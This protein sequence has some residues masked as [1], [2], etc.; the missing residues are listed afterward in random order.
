[1]TKK[2]HASHKPSKKGTPTGLELVSADAP[3]IPPE[4]RASA[5]HAA[6]GG[7]IVN[8]VI[9]G[10]V[11]LG[12]PGD[13]ALETKKTKK[14]TTDGSHAHG[15]TSATTTTDATLL[16]EKKRAG[17][18]RP[19]DHVVRPGA[20]AVHE[21][22]FEMDRVGRMHS[23]SRGPELVEPD[24]GGA[25][26]LSASSGPL[27]PEYAEGSAG[28]AGTAATGDSYLARLARKRRKNKQAAG[29]VRGR[30]AAEFVLTA[31]VEPLDVPRP[32]EIEG[33]R[34]G[35]GG[36]PV[37]GG[38]LEQRAV[39]EDGLSLTSPLGVGHGP[40]HDRDRRS[41]RHRHRHRHR[42]GDVENRGSFSDS[43]D[44][45]DSRSYDSR[46]DYHEYQRRQLQHQL[47]LQHQQRLSYQE[48][49][50]RSTNPKQW[51]K[52]QLR[53]A[54]CSILNFIL[55]IVIIA[56][57][58][59]IAKN[60]RDGSNNNNNN[61]MNDDNSNS[62]NTIVTN[63]TNTDDASFPSFAP[64]PSCLQ[65]SFRQLLLPRSVVCPDFDNNNNNNDA[66]SSC[67]E[68][69]MAVD[70]NHSVVTVG[71]TVY[72]FR[73]TDEAV[74]DVDVTAD[75]NSNSTNDENATAVGTIFSS[76]TT[77]NDGT[78]S[79]KN[80]QTIQLHSSNEYLP[81]AISQDTVVVG[82]PTETK[83]STNGVAYIYE[84]IQGDAATADDPPLWAVVDQLEHGWTNTD[85]ELDAG[86][87]SSFGK[88]VDVRDGESSMDLP[89][90]RYGMRW[91]IGTRNRWHFFFFNHSLTSL[92]FFPQ[93]P[94][95]VSSP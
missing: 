22:A 30:P 39:G 72:F 78:Y 17:R 18:H 82:A 67:P 46:E 69:F 74:V 92:L 26:R 44:D 25:A 93:H 29:N 71:N 31:E 59:V 87:V 56:M 45:D 66:S 90:R 3:P 6:G 76:S 55:I 54:L 63:T 65:S 9:D 95:Q 34:G 1:M 57:G 19:P 85:V 73:Y 47:E 32:T 38:V 50:I 77:T 70:G 43:H 14:T 12:V 20:Q 91:M 79:W 58:V 89:K 40:S 42:H 80:T 10:V 48:T 15:S 75:A 36:G 35:R 5:N 16:Q 41:R 61:N 88:T 4:F 84:W 27:P 11:E 49:S 94:T 7:G 51:S 37:V 81:V 64:M 86:V 8:R 83:D 53:F 21:P 52:Y 28:G 2:E 62:A 13:R 60:N 23:H 33:G 24:A 68:I